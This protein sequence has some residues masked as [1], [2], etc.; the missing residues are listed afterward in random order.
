MKFP[1]FKRPGSAS[2]T[3]PS[4]SS[5]SASISS[6]AS[7]SLSKNV[8]HVGLGG[9]NGVGTGIAKP[10]SRPTTGSSRPQTG[11]STKVWENRVWENHGLGGW[12]GVS[13]QDKAR[14]KKETKIVTDTAVEE[15]DAVQAL[16]IVEET[17]E[18]TVAPT[19]K[20]EKKKKAA[21]NT[22]SD[23]D[24]VQVMVIGA[25]SEEEE[26]ALPPPKKEKKK[27]VITTSSS[28]KDVTAKREDKVDMKELSKKSQSMKDL[29]RPM[30]LEDVDGES[31]GYSDSEVE[32]MKKKAAIQNRIGFRQRIGAQ[33]APGAVASD[34]EQEVVTQPNKAFANKRRSTASCDSDWSV[35]ELHQ[36]IKD[37]QKTAN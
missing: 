11:S 35:E 19:P 10:G 16:T 30:V 6:S 25:E 22:E 17:P 14:K 20:K 24:K 1:S 18:E 7:A 28:M 37:L 27:K 8:E 21:K 15:G 13:T 29:T 36:T 3:R 2:S 4:T 31:D 12:N 26:E 23:K 9:W 5:S 34:S 33:L 32:G